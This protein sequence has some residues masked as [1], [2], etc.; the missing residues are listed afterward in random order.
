MEK[1]L[2]LDFHLHIKT[3][4]F[5]LRPII[6]EIRKY[7]KDIIVYGN[8][9]EYRLGWYESYLNFGNEF[10]KDELFDELEKVLIEKN[11]NFYLIVGS[12][13]NE[14]FSHFT[15]YPLKNFHVIYWSTFL[16]SHTFSNLQEKYLTQ[17]I[18]KKFDHL[19]ITYNNKTRFH[20]RVMMDEL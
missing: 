1:I 16:L 12:H 20:R 19:F 11:A 9:S 6:D 2:Y 4:D 17:R 15:T 10:I 5:T 18:N 13:Q 14:V 7:D 3:N 8:Q